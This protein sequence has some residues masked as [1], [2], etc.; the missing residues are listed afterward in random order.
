MR[1]SNQDGGNNFSGV[2]SAR[3]FCNTAVFMGHKYIINRQLVEKQAA[4]LL[5][6][7]YYAGL[8]LLGGDKI[9]QADKTRRAYLLLQYSAIMSDSENSSRIPQTS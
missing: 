6:K 7:N 1:F 3:C 8:F 4:C 9:K 2:D 5:L